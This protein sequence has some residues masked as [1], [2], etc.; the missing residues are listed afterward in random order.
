MPDLDL[1]LRVFMPAF[2]IA[3]VLI[4]YTT[5]V[6]A[7]KRRHGFDPRVTGPEDPVLYLCQIYRNA[8]VIG[9]FV[10]VSIYAASPALY[11]WLMP[12]RFLEIPALRIVG[13]AAMIAGTFALRLA[14]YQLGEAWRIGIDRSGTV[15]ALVTTGLYRRSRNP[16]A[17]SMT[18]TVTGIFLALPNALTLV[19]VL[20]TILLFQVRV[21]IEEEH[22]TQLHGAA[23]EAYLQRTRRWI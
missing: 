12:V 17:L 8:I 21:R 7:F 15:T 2:M 11:K 3:Y 19:V 22:L 4:T 5:N 16:I 20:Q 14:Q 13:M 1:I 6:A 10:I 18:M 23:F 9:L